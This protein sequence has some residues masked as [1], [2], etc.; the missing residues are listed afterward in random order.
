M[1][2]IRKLHKNHV[3][4]HGSLVVKNRFLVAEVAGVIQSLQ[5]KQHHQNVRRH[6]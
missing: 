3:F 5:V 4:L 6:V 2:G 1:K